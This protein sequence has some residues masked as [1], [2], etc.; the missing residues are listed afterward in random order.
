MWNDFS[1]KSADY[2]FVSFYATTKLLIR[3]KGLLLFL[4]CLPALYMSTVIPLGDFYVLALHAIC[5]L[6]I[7]RD[8]GQMVG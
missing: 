7:M 4:Q 6:A 1:L 8:I 2:R 5:R 3:E